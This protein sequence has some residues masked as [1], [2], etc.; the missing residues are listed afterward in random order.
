LALVRIFAGRKKWEITSDLVENV[1]FETETWLKFQDETETSPKTLRPRRETWRSWPRLRLQNFCILPKFFE[2]ISSWLLTLFFFKFLAFFW[3]GLVV[4]YLQIEQ[5][6]KRWIT[7]IL[8]N[9]FFAIFKVSRPETFETETRPET[10]ETRLAKM[11]LNSSRDSITGN[12]N[13]IVKYYL[14]TLQYCK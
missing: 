9:H 13:T 1:T 11:G 8:I 6:K 5:T 14:T 3:C 2:K 4:S 10:F 12:H 7:E